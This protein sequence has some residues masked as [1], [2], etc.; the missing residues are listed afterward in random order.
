MA[1]TEV[2]Q[3]ASSEVTE[4]T[5][6]TMAPELLIKHDL[7]TSWTLWY[8]EN[9]KDRKWEDNLVPIITFGTVEDFWA[10]YNYLEPASNLQIGSDYALFKTGIKPMWEDE[11]NKPGGRWLI[12]LDKSRGQAQDNLDIYWLDLMLLMIGEG[13]GEHGEVVNGAVINRRIKGNKIALWTSDA[14]KREANM[15]AGRCMKE[16][17]QMPPNSSLAF[18]VHSDTSSRNSSTAKCLYKV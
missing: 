3:N 18:Q 6:S 12:S 10:A 14:N 5:L 15:H 1:S 16:A 13:F 8:Y 4:E 9:I 17:L 11:Q 2:Q 7:H